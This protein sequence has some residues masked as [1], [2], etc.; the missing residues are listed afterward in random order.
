MVYGT[1]FVFIVSTI[2]AVNAFRSILGRVPIAVTTARRAIEQRKAGQPVNDF[3][4]INKLFPLG[5]SFF[6]L[7]LWAVADTSPISVF[8]DVGIRKGAIEFFA[9]I[10]FFAVPYYILNEVIAPR[11]GLVKNEENG[12]ERASG[13]NPWE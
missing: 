12:D 6:S 10:I 13:R 4:V 7:P 5:L 9:T 2:I 3:K 11:L 1:L 8:E